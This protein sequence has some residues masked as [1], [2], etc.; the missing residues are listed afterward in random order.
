MSFENDCF[1][2]SMDLSDY[3]F[4]IVRLASLNKTPKEIEEILGL[5]DHTIHKKFHAYLMMGY[6][7]YFENH[8]WNVNMTYKRVAFLQRLRRRLNYVIREGFSEQV[9]AS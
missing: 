8:E 6:Q 9:F 2:K 1:V 4:E 5:A 7:Q 3:C